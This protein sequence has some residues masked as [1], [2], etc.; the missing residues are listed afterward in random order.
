M[1]RPI[2]QNLRTWAP[3]LVRI[4]MALVFLWFGIN[5][6]IEPRDFIGYLPGWTMSLPISASALVISNGVFEIVFGGLLLFGLFARLSAML[7]SLHLFAIA[8]SL[9]YNDIAVRD[10]GLALATLSVALHGK[11]RWSIS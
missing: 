4:A 8:F 6:L 5:Q 11:D 3:V 7:L 9:G 2:N 1:N 10:I